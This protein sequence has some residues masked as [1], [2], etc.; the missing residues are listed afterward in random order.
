MVR[1]VLVIVALPQGLQVIKI[2]VIFY[3]CRS[4]DLFL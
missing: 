1:F 3:S 4:S 2:N